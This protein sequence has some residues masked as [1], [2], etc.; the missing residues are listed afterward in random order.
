MI[1]RAVTTAVPLRHQ[2]GGAGSPDKPSLQ[3]DDTN[4]RFAA[5]RQSFL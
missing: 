2:A 3:D 5:E 1:R 4:A